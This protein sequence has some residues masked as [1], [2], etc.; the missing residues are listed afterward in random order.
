[1]IFKEDF[2]LLSTSSFTSKG[3]IFTRCP[4]IHLCG[5]ICLYHPRMLELPAVTK[6]IHFKAVVLKFYGCLWC[7]YKNCELL[8][9]RQV[10]L[11]QIVSC[12]GFLEVR[13]FQCFTG[14]LAGL[15]V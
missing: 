5:Q 12:S 7:Q 11:S 10:F 3:S 4:N 8:N 6:N 14:N 13:V 15:A 2:F 1:M 9:Q